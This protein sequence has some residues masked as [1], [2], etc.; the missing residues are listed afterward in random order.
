MNAGSQDWFVFV[1]VLNT[2]STASMSQTPDLRWISCLDTEHS[3]SRGMFFETL[4]QQRGMASTGTK[5][6]SAIDWELKLL[7][8]AQTSCRMCWAQKTRRTETDKSSIIEGMFDVPMKQSGACHEL[9]TLTHHLF[10]LFYKYVC[11]W[12]SNVWLYW[13]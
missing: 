13:C 11:L 9:S 4:T 3:M 12:Q 1:F 8:K 10:K 6:T 7:T 5:A 2:H